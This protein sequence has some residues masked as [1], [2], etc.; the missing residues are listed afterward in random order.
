[1]T[2]G[3][4][5]NEALFGCMA[6]PPGHRWRNYGIICKTGDIIEMVVNFDKLQMKYIING[7]DYGLSC[8]IEQNNYS[9]VVLI[10]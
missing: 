10:D 6:N 4:S 7:K 3:F 1:M 8:N 9:A 5:C 2:Y